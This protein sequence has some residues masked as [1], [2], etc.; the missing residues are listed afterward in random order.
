MDTS[1]TRS[2]AG[3]PDYFAAGVS[4]GQQ[5]VLDVLKR[6]G[7]STVPELALALELNVETVR[8]HVRSLERSGYARRADT[9]RSGP[10]R[11]ELL[12]GLTSQA[13]TLFPRS[14]GAIL[15]ALA[16]HLQATGNELLLREFFEAYVS[17][18]RD[19]AM[20][21]VEGLTGAARVEEVARIMSE[22]G[23]MAT[24]GQAGD[25]PGLHLCHCPLR[26]LVEVT[27]IP[28]RAELGFIRE[29]LGEPLTRLSYIPAGDATCSYRA[30]AS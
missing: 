20:A 4:P 28:C 27:R 22:F 26:E 14:E 25:E 18:R 9:R 6:R 15:G 11:P 30:Q 10:G 17:A 3:R 23:F 7:D 12:Y 13:E 21:R 16:A 1:D 5:R 2:T 19:E 29:L 8:Y 24:A